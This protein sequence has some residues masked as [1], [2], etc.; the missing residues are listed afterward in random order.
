MTAVILQ[1]DRT[2]QHEPLIVEASEPRP[3]GYVTIRN[4]NGALLHV[5]AWA[6][7]RIA[8]TTK[9]VLVVDVDGV[10]HEPGAT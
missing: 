6:W 10:E 5:P 4:N 1:F 8:A 7:E 2:R 9:K 3:P